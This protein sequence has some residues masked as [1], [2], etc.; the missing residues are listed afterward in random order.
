[1]RHLRAEALK[2]Q[3][4]HGPNYKQGNWLDDKTLCS[5]VLSLVDTPDCDSES[6][7]EVSRRE[8]TSVHQQ[9]TNSWED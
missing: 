3:K 8:E 6:D 4:D 1:M 5:G 9:Q 7:D 2:V